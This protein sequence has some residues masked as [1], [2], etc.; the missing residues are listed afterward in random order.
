MKHLPVL[1]LAALLGAGSY[2]LAQEAPA[3]S[4]PEALIAYEYDTVCFQ[5]YS[6]SC[7]GEN[8]K[9]EASVVVD[10]Q[11]SRGV[12]DPVY[13]GCVVE[14]LNEAGREGWLLGTYGSLDFYA[15]LPN[16]TH[17]IRRAVDRPVKP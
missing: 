12:R 14:W 17:L 3:P 1:L 5:Q 16:R 8:K 6:H 13:W 9:K 2:A 4:S 15:P 11:G 10:C 7:V